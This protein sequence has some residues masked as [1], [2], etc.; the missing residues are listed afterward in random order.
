MPPVSI[1]GLSIDDQVTLNL[2]L[3]RMDEKV[4]RNQLRTTYYD[5]KYRFHDLM[6]STPPRL[7]DKIDLVLDWPAKAVDLLS[8]RITID[9]FVTPE[10]DDPGI[11]EIW[12]ANSLDIEAPQGHDSALIHSCAFVWTTLGDVRA[13]EPPVIVHVVSARNGTGIWDPRRRRLSAAL[14]VVERS[15]EGGDPTLMVMALPDRVATLEKLPGGRWVVDVRP[16]SLGYV[17]VEVMP[18]R[19]NL[20]RPFGRSRISRTIMSLTD[21][22]LRTAVRSEVGG[23][24][25]AAPRVAA[26]NTPKDAFENGG[27]DAVTSHAL[28][29]DAP[30]ADDMDAD[31]QWQPSITQLAQVSMQPH[32]EQLRMFATLFA[33]AAEL[34]LDAVGIVQDN[35]SSA[36]AIEKAEKNLALEAERTA[37]VFG[38]GWVRA[39][40]TAWILRNGTTDASALDGLEVVWRNPRMP[41]MSAASDAILKQVSTPGLEW[42]GG[43]EVAL[44]KLGYDRP[45]I[46]RLLAEKKRADGGSLLDKLRTQSAPTQQVN[47]GNGD[48]TP[49]S[50][51]PAE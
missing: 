12:Q 20:D 46:R 24:F 48:G 5:A 32:V 8:Q 9:G 4:V 21:A 39:M 10:S 41:S 40:R 15:V 42:I 34:P 16:H 6:I 23:E 1:P 49:Q 33:S 28:V 14:Q 2:L 11:E 35:P 47:D 22:A 17:P 13:G 26:L 45:T 29:I 50:D 37:K 31:P 25:F 38:R 3:N 43:T 27:W 7:R 30:D 51:R 18:Y 44:E 36:E 19:P